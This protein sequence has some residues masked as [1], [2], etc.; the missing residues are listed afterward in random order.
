MEN[1][2]PGAI[3]S[4]VIRYVTNRIIQ[5]K[6][7]RNGM[8]KMMQ[9][10]GRIGEPEEVAEAAMWLCSDSASFVTGHCLVID[11]GMTVT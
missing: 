1:M 6:L 9:P 2:A 7:V 5:S 4:P 10:L 3:Q 8:Q 11:G